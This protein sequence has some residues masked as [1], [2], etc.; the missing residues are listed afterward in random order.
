MGASFSHHLVWGTKWFEEHD[1]VPEKLENMTPLWRMEMLP[2]SP[3]ETVHINLPCQTTESSTPLRD[4]AQA[5]N[6]LMKWHQD[7]PPIVSLDFIGF[8]SGTSEKVQH[9]FHTAILNLVSMTNWMC[10]KANFRM[11]WSWVKKCVAAVKTL[12]AGNAILTEP[13]ITQTLPS[14]VLRSEN[15]HS[16]GYKTLASTEAF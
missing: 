5:H 3:A 10:P 12:V 11:P 4:V 15:T 6:K 7:P 14:L 2:P 1:P 8:E 16:T 9:T 13:A